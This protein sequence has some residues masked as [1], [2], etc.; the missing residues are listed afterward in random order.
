MLH[1][2]FRALLLY[3]QS[4]LYGWGPDTKIILLI[5]IWALYNDQLAVISSFLFSLF[6]TSFL[7]GRLVLSSLIVVLILPSFCHSYSYSLMNN[8]NTNIISCAHFTFYLLTTLLFITRSGLNEELENKM[9]CSTTQVR[10]FSL[11]D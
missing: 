3:S 8:D 10:H 2:I 7:F 6:F 11:T 4:I 5:K 1:I 9:E